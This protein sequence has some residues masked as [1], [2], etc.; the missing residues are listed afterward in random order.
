[1]LVNVEGG[2]TLIDKT[3]ADALFAP[4]LHVVRNS[5]AHG[6]ETAGERGRQGK[7]LEGQL[8]LRGREESGEVVIEVEDDGRGL[9]LTAL[10]GR[11]IAM[12]LLDPATSVDD[13]RVRELIFASGLSTKATAGD[14]A[15]RGLGGDIVKRSVEHLNGSVEVETAA[16][17]GTLLRIRLPASLAIAKVFIVESHSRHFAVPMF[18]AER[19]FEVSEVTMTRSNQEHYLK[20]DG[21]LIRAFNVAELTQLQSF[22]TSQ[23]GTVIV[24]RVGV[25]RFALIVDRVLGQEDAVIKTAGDLLNGHP[26]F[27]GVTLRGNGQM[28]LVLDVPSIGDLVSTTHTRG[29]TDNKAQ[30]P[31]VQ[32]L[33]SAPEAPTKA[34][35]PPNAATTARRV[36]VLYVDDSLSVRKVAEKMLT[37]LGADVSVAVD[38]V[39]ALEKLRGAEFDIVFSDIEMPRMHGYELVR[40]IRFLPNLRELP[41]IMVTSRSGT[42]HRE[43]AAQAGASGYLTK[44]FNMQSLQEMIQRWGKRPE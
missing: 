21:E 19:M 23:S 34:L 35:L 24:M 36:R 29:R 31:K 2:A 26:L 42:K 13:P 38:G 3:L 37:Q 28:L 27:A 30:S 12:G 11:G 33:R 1:V 41:V 44:P 43:E 25:R 32:A 16:G 15:G 6:I 39:E 5:V 4:L 40:E 14:V 18:F 7:P 10:R 8:R 20:Y 17:K 22:Q 9:D